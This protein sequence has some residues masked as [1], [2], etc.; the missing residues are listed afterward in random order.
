MNIF[1]QALLIFGIYV[2]VFFLMIL[3]S[4][5]LGE[6][7]VTYLILFFYEFPIYIKMET[8]FTN[9][10]FSFLVNSI[11]WTLIILFAITA[12]KKLLFQNKE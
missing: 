12:I 1:K 2:L 7:I 9:F 5:K 3:L 11:F 6:N 4:F 10:I 8:T